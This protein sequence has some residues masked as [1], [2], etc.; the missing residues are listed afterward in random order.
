M[1]LLEGSFTLY[2]SLSVKVSRIGAKLVCLSITSKQAKVAPECC[3]AVQGWKWRCPLTFTPS[4][5]LLRLRA[6]DSEWKML[7]NSVCRTCLGAP[8]CLRWN[9]AVSSGAETSEVDSQELCSRPYPFHLI[10]YWNLLRCQQLSSISSTSH[11][12]SPSTTM[13]GGWSSILHPVIR[14]S[15]ARVSFTTLNTR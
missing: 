6:I 11:S 10:R 14:S 2:T 3:Q 13:G 7:L 5:R 12:A 1:R 8:G 9:S 4:S 15:G